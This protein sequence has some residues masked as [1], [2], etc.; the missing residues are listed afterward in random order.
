[1]IEN[2]IPVNL[3]IDNKHTEG[4]FIGMWRRN[5]F[6]TIL[7]SGIEF[8]KYQTKPVIFRVISKAV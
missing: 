5:F 4:W 2:F 7:K 1:M 8:E 3:N 6:N